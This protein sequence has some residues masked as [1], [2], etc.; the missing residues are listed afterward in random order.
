[1]KFWYLLNQVNNFAFSEDAVL[2]SKTTLLNRWMVES[3][4]NIALSATNY[5]CGFVQSTL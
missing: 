3:P 4:E 2:W 1:M 5:S